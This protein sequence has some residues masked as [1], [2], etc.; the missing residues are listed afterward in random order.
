MA[1]GLGLAATACDPPAPPPV[2]QQPLTDLVGELD[3]ASQ[4]IGCERASQAITITVTS[5]LDPS[6]TYTGGITITGSEVTFDCRGAHIDDAAGNGSRGVAVSSPIDQP[7]VH[8]VTVRN[9]LITGFVNT[10]RVTRPGFRQ[11][12]LGDEYADGTSNIV[13][14]NNHLYASRGS[15]VFVDAY[16]TDVTLRDLEIAGAGSVGIYLEAGS[17]DNLVEGNDIQRNG[18]K[19]V[20]GE[21]AV[22]DLGG[23][24]TVR[25]HSTGREGIAIDGSRDNVVRDNTLGLNANGGILVYKNCGEFATT[26]PGQW[27]TRPYGADGNVI[28]G[29]RFVAERY[30]VWVGSRM[31]ENQ[32]FMDCSD[33]AYVDEPLARYHRDVARDNVVRDNEF[34]GVTYGVRIE[35]DRATVEGNTFANTNP[36]SVA[37]V[38]GSRQRTELLDDPVDGTTVVGNVATAAA[39]RDAY[40]WV[41]GEESTTFSGNTTNGA[42]TPAL[43][44]GTQP[45]QDPFL[46]VKDFWVP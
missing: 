23:G 44:E 13:I 25:Y 40:V 15:G 27:W 31:S 33:P 35:D 1:V 20:Y 7:G 43:V 38:V 8:D 22:F 19:D 4:L 46:M 24:R 5:H 2:T 42:A 17:K 12:P 9:C 28:E 3:P 14:E 10:I 29:N 45:P 6:C 18:Y 36:A 21:G 16:V 11:L 39:G 34:V 37:V 32:R 41:H 30:G 26:E